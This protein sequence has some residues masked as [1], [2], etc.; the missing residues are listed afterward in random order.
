MWQMDFS[1]IVT[2]AT[3]QQSQ[4]MGV[5]VYTILLYVEHQMAFIPG[6]MDIEQKLFP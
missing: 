5:K 6:T 2:M 4:L 3:Y 1:L